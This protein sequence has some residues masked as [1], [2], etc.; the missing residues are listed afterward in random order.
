MDAST[1][2][3]IEPRL[4]TTLTVQK[5]VVSLGATDAR[6][7]FIEGTGVDDRRVVVDAS[8]AALNEALGVVT[9]ACENCELG[10]DTISVEVEDGGFSGLG[11]PLTASG[12]VEVSIVRR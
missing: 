6:L 1:G 11:G 3:R 8:V 10:S 7:S 9:Y 12:S 4:V 5:G 2:L